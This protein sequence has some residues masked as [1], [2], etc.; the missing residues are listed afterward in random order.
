MRS[1]ISPP[2]SSDRRRGAALWAAV[3][4]APVLWL[5]LLQT[6][7]ILA[8]PTCAARSNGWLHLT[9]AA[10]LGLMVL[11]FVAAGY[12][13]RTDPPEQRRGPA[14]LAEQHDPLGEDPSLAARHFVAVLGLLLS[15]LFVLLVAGTW[16]PAFILRPCD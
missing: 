16:I 2:T 6:N 14:R 3:V 11:L 10:A 4:A 1:S 5:I 12:V 15:A 13:W 8:Y 9:T 7:Y